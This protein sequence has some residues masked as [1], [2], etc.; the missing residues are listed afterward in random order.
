MNYAEKIH[1]HN[2]MSQAYAG[3][4]LLLDTLG[5]FS[6][7]GYYHELS[8]RFTG[9]ATDDLTLASACV[10]RAIHLDYTGQWDQALAQYERAA[11][12]YE[13]IGH[14]KKWG[15]PV[16]LMSFIF[17]HHGEFDKSREY[18]QKLIQ[19]G[20]E[21]GDRQLKGWGLGAS[22]F[23]QIRNGDFEA[24]ARD[25][26]QAKTL[27]ES[28]PDYYALVPVH[29][30]RISCYLCMEDYSKAHAALKSAGKLVERKHLKGFILSLFYNAA[31]EFYLTVYE[32]SIQIEEKV[33]LRKLKKYA[34]RSIRH[35]SRFKCGLP[36]ACRL[37]GWFCSMAGNSGKAEQFWQQGLSVARGLGAKFEEGLICFE[38]GRCLDDIERLKS[39]GSIFETINAKAELSRV[40]AQIAVVEKGHPLVDHGKRAFK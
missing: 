40:D 18:A 31:C 29:V 7:A 34:A 13:K 24:A 26:D 5:R 4:G 35:G 14:I 27:L 38:M 36:K 22:G 39:A 2:K 15:S 3:F 1:H 9:P 8:R 32:K 10:C 12:L 17:N 33:T 23:Y 21:S 30:D 19:I 6:L 16:S 11:N 20:M 37:N 25:L 28:I